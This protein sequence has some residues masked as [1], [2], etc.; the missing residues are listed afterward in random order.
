MLTHDPMSAP[1]VE[2]IAPAFS[3][4]IRLRSASGGRPAPVRL[5]PR[6][7]RTLS[8]LLRRYADTHQETSDD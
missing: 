7:A 4:S 8:D 2:V 3:G 6:D 5:T 1:H